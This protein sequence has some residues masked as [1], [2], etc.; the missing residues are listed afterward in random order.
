MATSELQDRLD[1]LVSYASQLIFINGETTD[2]SSILDTFISDSPEQIEIALLTASPTTVL[3]QYRERLYRQLIS[4]TKLT[5]FN[6][7]LNQLLVA[8]NQHNGPL[9][10]SI[11]KAENLPDKLLQELWELVLQSRFANNKQHL[12]VLLFA[13]GAWAKQARNKLQSRSGDKPL[14]LNN[15]ARLPNITQSTS[16]LDELITLK[17]QQFAERVQKRD[18]AQTS[19]LPL[20]KRKAVIALFVCI[21]L[22]LFAGILSLQ[23]LYLFTPENEV[24][25]NVTEQKS[26]L[27]SAQNDAV[28]TAALTLEQE[29]KLSTQS[30]TDIEITEP[31][32]NQI[33][34]NN[35]VLT[36]EKTSSPDPLVTSWRSAIAKMEE[37][38][39]Q[40]LLAKPQE[41][42]IEKQ[43]MAIP[44]HSTRSVTNPVKQTLVESKN[45]VTPITDH[46]N[47]SRTE[48]SRTFPSE[49]AL[50][51]GQYLIQISAMSDNYLLQQFMQE[52]PLS[53]QVWS[54][55]TKRFGG[56]WF[57]LLFNH[58]YPS[59]EQARAALDK[60]PTSIAAYEPFVKSAR[61]I[62]QELLQKEV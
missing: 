40:Y 58:V 44:D 59:L 57:V 62:K 56:D 17:R 22:L 54:Y 50:E 29:S 37:N 41:A 12:N 43:T 2:Q 55:T 35:D 3:A 45:V 60:L 33:A 53:Q 49:L 16:N 6:R 48:S 47:S 11:S 10:I 32:T 30:V 14:L 1:Y 23:Y 36:A 42:V 24:V 31:S 8:L 20:L 51:D 9:I 15:S 21:F 61:Q 25:T 38:P 4:Q 46:V 7:P 26:E 52:N 13:Q 27:S 28:I 18:Q 5:D 34:E 19:V 39:S